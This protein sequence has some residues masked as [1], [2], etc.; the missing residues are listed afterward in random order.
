MSSELVAGLIGSAAGFGLGYAYGSGWFTKPKFAY[1]IS[2]YSLKATWQGTTMD[3][4][5]V[6]IPQQSTGDELWL[7]LAPDGGIWAVTKMWERTD[8]VSFET[9]RLA[10]AEI[11]IYRMGV[12]VGTFPQVTQSET[13]V[14]GYYSTVEPFELTSGGGGKLTI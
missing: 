11:R 1:I 3:L 9:A 2:R 5:P 4:R 7:W 14:Y 6:F 12:L 13:V 8:G 10:W